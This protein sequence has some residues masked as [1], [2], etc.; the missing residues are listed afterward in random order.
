MNEVR[1]RAKK[2]GIENPLKI[3]TPEKDRIRETLVRL[4]TVLWGAAAQ[5]IKPIRAPVGGRAHAEA[6]HTP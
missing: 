1:K 6:M 3:N 4:L 2:K 5:G